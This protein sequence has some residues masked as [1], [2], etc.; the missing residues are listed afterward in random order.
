MDNRLMLI[1]VGERW[2][3]HA[4][5]TRIRDFVRP[6]SEIA[7]RMSQVAAVH[8]VMIRASR[9]GATLGDVFEAAQRAYAH[10]GV[11]D[12]WTLHHQ[13]GTIGYQPRET[14][15]GPGDKT[16]IEAGMALAWN[17]SITG[18]KAES[19]ILVQRDGPPLDVTQAQQVGGLDRDD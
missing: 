19:T 9:P 5:F 15:A 3:L 16:V 17:P 11:P 2:G 12:E 6:R 18:A 7:E 13:G 4:A 8:E 10:A 14:I 1:A